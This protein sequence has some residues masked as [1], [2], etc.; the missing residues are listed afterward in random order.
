MNYERSWN[1]F[2]AI[3][4]KADLTNDDGFGRGLKELSKSDTAK[5][6]FLL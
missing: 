5:S 6:E 4:N 2:S 1:S 3:I